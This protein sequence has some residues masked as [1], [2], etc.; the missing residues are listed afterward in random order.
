MSAN[1]VG[2]ISALVLV[3][4]DEMAPAD[5]T[6]PPALVTSFPRLFESESGL[7]ND[8]PETETEPEC[9]GRDRR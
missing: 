4:V 9:E 5:E 3:S 2:T 1:P 8:E 7:E 6:P